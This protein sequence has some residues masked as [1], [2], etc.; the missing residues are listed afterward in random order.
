MVGSTRGLN[1]ILLV[2]KLLAQDNLLL[3]GNILNRPL[4]SLQS[5]INAGLLLL[6]ILNAGGL[7][8]LHLLIELSKKLNVTCDK[9]K[10]Q[11][12]SLYSS[13]SGHRACDKYSDDFGRDEDGLGIDLPSA[14]GSR[15]TLDVEKAA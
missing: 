15:K 12:I 3:A 5:V 8:V 7:L 4:A 9:M 14:A 13:F 10:N 11:N 2:A 1:C 6:S